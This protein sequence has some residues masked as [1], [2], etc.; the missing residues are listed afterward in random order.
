MRPPKTR[1]ALC[2]SRSYLQAALPVIC[3]KG[4]RSLTLSAFPFSLLP[5]PTKALGAQPHPTKGPGGDFA[6]G[7]LPLSRQRESGPRLGLPGSASGS[8]QC[9]QGCR[10]PPPG[11]CAFGNVSKSRTGSA[12]VMGNL[13]GAGPRCRACGSRRTAVRRR[14]RRRGTGRGFE[15]ALQ[16]PAPRPQGPALATGRCWRPCRPARRGASRRA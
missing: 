2:T 9:V 11:K 1:S 16:A 12:P 13:G 5:I 14:E 3:M 6:F 7:L 8:I 4:R 15:R 10:S